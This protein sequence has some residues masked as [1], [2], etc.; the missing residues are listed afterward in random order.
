MGVQKRAE[1]EGGQ[2]I[3]GRG[4]TEGD[5]ATEWG[6][7]V[8]EHSARAFT[9]EEDRLVSLDGLASKIVKAGNNSYKPGTYFIGTWL[10]DIPE[11]ICWAS[12]RTGKKN[13]LCP[14][15][16]W[17]SCGG[18]VWFRFRDFDGNRPDEGFRSRC[19]ILA[20]DAASGILSIEATRLMVNHLVLSAIEENSLKDL[21]G[22]KGRL[23]YR[24]PL[25]QGY[26]IG[27]RDEESYGWIE[28]D[29]GRVA[30]DIMEPV[31]FL[32][33]EEAEYWSAPQVQYWGL[34]LVKDTT[35]HDAFNRVV[36]GSVWDR[37]WMAS[38]EH[39]RTAIV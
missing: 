34:L 36:M 35:R 12:Y 10:D 31:F 16:S 22:E 15:W 37:S 28:F 21:Y 23:A 8:A 39:Q 1:D 19:K 5:W 29:D 11:F 13:V 6:R 38:A 2:L 7:V 14:S 3:V 26:A 30:P 4:L 18:P 20:V 25:I 9:F 27:L 24:Q 33:L 32:C 17:A